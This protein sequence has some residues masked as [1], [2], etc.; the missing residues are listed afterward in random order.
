MI[1][2]GEDG[3]THINIYSRAKTKLGRWLSN[4][5]Y[6]PITLVDGDFDSIEGYWYWLFSGEERFK[7]LSGH[8]AK[9]LGKELVK[10]EEKVVDDVIKAK[11]KNAIDVKLK[12]YFDKATQLSRTTLPLC[13]YYEYG[14]KRVDAGHEWIV[15][16]IELRR[17]MLK[18][19]FLK[20]KGIFKNTE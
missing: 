18:E 9:K 7:T 19:Y 6:T 13:H 2:E 15:K 17:E 12:K 4:F 10:K 20:K 3:T 8:A 11:I 14:G 16:H 1:I 5:S